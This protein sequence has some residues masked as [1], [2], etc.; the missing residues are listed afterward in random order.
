MT[1]ITQ[2]AS[3]PRIAAESLTVI[4]FQNLPVITTELLAQLY[5]TDKDNIH[6]NFRRNEDRFVEGKHFFKLEGELLRE[7]KQSLSSFK[8]RSEDLLTD[9]KS[10]SADDEIVSPNTRHLTLW[11]ERGA[12]RHA[13]MLETDQA[14][15][16]FERLEDCYFSQRTPEASRKRGRMS[17]ISRLMELER[18]GNMLLKW[19]T[20]RDPMLKAA[21]A[22]VV[23]GMFSEAGLPAP[24]IGS[25][26]QPARTP[27]WAWLLLT[28][29]DAVDAQTITQPHCWATLDD[30]QVLLFRANFIYQWLDT[31]P[32]LYAEWRKRGALRERVF[33]RILAEQKLLLADGIER[34]LQGRRVPHLAALDIEA[35][36]R[37]LC[38]FAA[39]KSGVLQ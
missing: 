11:T 36:R 20:S 3:A 25:D 24:A 23:L 37:A 31:Q 39:P 19:H 8:L 1:D 21:L 9:L 7:F 14:W 17:H 22:P 5:G 18:A 6:A 4:R 2:G 13:K 35:A 33:K 12:A 15:E 32:A 38:A 26:G 27:P 30:K 29:L 10:V 28:W 34:T 16:V